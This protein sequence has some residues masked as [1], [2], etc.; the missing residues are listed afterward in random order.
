M[1]HLLELDVTE[2]AVQLRA[3]G[4]RVHMI[5]PQPSFLADRHSFSE[6]SAAVLSAGGAGKPVHHFYHRVTRASPRNS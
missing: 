6:K 3:V 1:S 2:Q 5:S 4:G